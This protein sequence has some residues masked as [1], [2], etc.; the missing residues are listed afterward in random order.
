MSLLK[1]VALK[2]ARPRE[3]GQCPALPLFAPHVSSL[4]SSESSEQQIGESGKMNLR[5][6]SPDLPP[7]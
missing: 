2:L 7:K 3:Q 4:S 5:H 1:K 6:F